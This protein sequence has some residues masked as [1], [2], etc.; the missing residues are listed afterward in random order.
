[1]TEPNDE[2]KCYNKSQLMSWL[3]G[4][5]KKTDRKDFAIIDKQSQSFVGEVVLNELVGNT[6]NLRVAILPEYFDKGHGTQ[7]IKMA[8]KYAFKNMGVSTITLGVYEINNRAL[9]VYKKCGF[10]KTGVIETAGGISEI[11]MELSQN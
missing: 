5:S 1:M 7:A 6:C 9:H 2:P 4:L 11:T 10:T 8:C 3:E